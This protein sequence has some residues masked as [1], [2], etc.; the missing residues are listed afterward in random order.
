M[1]D[2]RSSE[3]SA[4]KVFVQRTS[5]LDYE[6]SKTHPWTIRKFST[7]EVREPKMKDAHYTLCLNGKREP[8]Y[9]FVARQFLDA[10]ENDEIRLRKDVDKKEYSLTD[11]EVNKQKKKKKVVEESHEITS[12][13]VGESHINIKSKITFS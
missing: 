5:N 1:S 7:K 2:E 8:V 11:I 10:D 3:P 13:E 9:K 6:I 12:E 4:K